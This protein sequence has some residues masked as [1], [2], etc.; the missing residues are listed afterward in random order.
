MTGIQ[1]TSSATYRQLLG[2]G[3]T[4]EIPKFQ[5]D[6]SWTSEQWDDLWQDIQGLL[7]G[8]ESG[9]YMGYLVLQTTDN[10]V[11]QVIDGQQ[12]LTTLSIM[13]LATLKSLNDLVER[14]VDP[15]NNR[16][17]SDTLRGSYIGYLDPVTLVSRN[18]LKLNRNN[19]DYFRTYLVSLQQPRVR[20]INASERL[21]RGAYLWF[22]EKLRKAY[23][24]G[25]GLAQFVDTIVDKLQFT[26]IKVDDDLNAFK[27]F[28]TLNAR[29]VQLSSADLLKNYLFSVVDSDERHSSE[30]L[31]MEHL[32]SAVMGVLAGERFEE[33]LRTFWNSRFENV[34][35]NDLFKVI[36]KRVRT[37][38]DAFTLL[39]SLH[40]TAHVYMALR[41]PEDELW[42]DMPEA[43]T[44]LSLLRMYQVR[45]PFPM[46]LAAYQGLER[47]RFL[48][49]LK[50]CTVISMRYN[51][52][53]GLNPNEQDR[54]Y[55]DAALRIHRERRFELEWMRDIYTDDERFAAAFATADFKDTPRNNKIVKYILAAI[56]RKVHGGVIDPLGQGYSIEHVL[57]ESPGGDWSMEEEA[58][59]RSL[60]R[61]G[62]LA[63]LEPA[64]NRDAGTQ[65]FSRKRSIYL[66][67]DIS[68]TRA[69]AERYETWDEEQIGTR[70]RHMADVAKEIWRLPMQ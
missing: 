38:G 61:L 11:F 51:V 17:R 67:S 46:L 69:L 15:D 39:R 49:V 3:L 57:P 55:N 24:T 42:K 52:I 48:A 59:E 18:K 21:M 30:L 19:D 26:V 25:E 20:N 31:E 10:K 9:H 54:V 34:R 4:Y 7:S 66:R 33:F 32:W 16:R 8:E 68:S 22:Y 37:K 23:E 53:G 41:S 28:E 63:L 29:G 58:M 5:R 13:V 65:A 44:D 70:Q 27:V 6:Y 50:A 14:G 36:R 40:E 12:R 60:Y 43:R 47:N 56:E 62:N 45:Q 35:K 1:D 2:N 64:L